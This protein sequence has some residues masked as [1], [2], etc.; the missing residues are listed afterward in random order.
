MG[1]GGLSV[2]FQI[3]ETQ[4]LRKQEKENAGLC[5][6]FACK[7]SALDMKVFVH[8]K[9]HM[10][11]GFTMQQELYRLGLTALSPFSPPHILALKMEDVAAVWN[12]VTK[13]HNSLVATRPAYAL[14][15]TKA[16]C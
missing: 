6:L 7:S 16:A 12:E 9:Q 3:D 4:R 2:Y 5:D 15:M 13:A 1:G 8:W 10:S 14:L 11:S